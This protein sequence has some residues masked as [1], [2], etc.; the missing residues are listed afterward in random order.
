MCRPSDSVS[1]RATR[2]LCAL[3]GALFVGKSKESFFVGNRNL[4]LFVVTATLA[5]QSLDANAALGNLDLGYKPRRALALAVPNRISRHRE[6][7]AFGC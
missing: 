4:N 2:F 3:S 7:A 6:H 1:R 5:S